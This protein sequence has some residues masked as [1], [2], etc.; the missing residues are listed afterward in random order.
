[1]LKIKELCKIKGISLAELAKKLGVTP[2]ALS[3]NISGNPNLERLQEIANIL[4]V[5]ITDLF[6]QPNESILN[7][8]YCGGKIKVG[9]E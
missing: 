5:H 8:P 3:Q 9:K 2:S 1:M 4:E 7:C 6:D